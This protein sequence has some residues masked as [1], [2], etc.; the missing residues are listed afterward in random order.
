VFILGL[1]TLG[2]VYVDLNTTDA[3]IEWMHKNYSIPSNVRILQI[4]GK[5]LEL[6]PLFTWFP[7]FII[8]LWGFKEFKKN[9]L[10]CLLVCQLVIGC[11]SGVYRII[12]VDE[13]TATKVDFN[14]Y[15]LVIILCPQKCPLPTMLCQLTWRNFFHTSFYF[16]NL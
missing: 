13:V 6:F 15:R 2:L 1:L 9:D 3:C 7:A 5:S 4:V 16:W 14:K 10:L 8:M 11:I 12:M